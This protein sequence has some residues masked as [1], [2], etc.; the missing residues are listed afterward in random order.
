MR[1]KM[2]MG[3]IVVGG[4]MT[5]GTAGV[6]AQTVAPYGTTPPTVAPTTVVTA[7]VAP[8]T[9]VKIV[10]AISPAVAGVEVAADPALAGSRLPVTGG[11]ISAL[12]ALGLAGLGLIGVRSARRRT[13]QN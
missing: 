9:T 6:G 12:G 7:T 2:L 13:A 1:N 10:G 5:L 11:D 3:T 4:F 8:T